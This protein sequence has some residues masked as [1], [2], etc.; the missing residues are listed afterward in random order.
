MGGSARD[1]RVARCRL[2]SRLAALARGRATAWR[3]PK[4]TNYAS[5][6]RS[7]TPAIPGLTVEVRDLGSRLKSGTR[8]RTT[9]SFSG[10]PGEPYLRVGPAGV[11]ENRRS[12]AVF[13]NRTQTIVAERAVVVRRRRAY[14]VAS[15]R[16]RPGRVL[17]RPPRPLDGRVRNRRRC[18][19]T[20]VA[21]HLVA[22]GSSRFSTTGRACGARRPS[23]GTRSV[24]S[25]TVKAQS[26]RSIEPRCLKP[27]RPFSRGGLSRRWDARRQADPDYALDRAAETLELFPAARVI[28]RPQGQTAV[29]VSLVYK[30]WF[31]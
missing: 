25:R 12:P 7:V 23:L 29:S 27:C 19:P 16:R 3:A 24:R 31:R 17:A 11:Y 14:R 1:R 5:R 9:S 22:T 2:R 10:T 15:H 4:P 20:P 8:P 6:V 26:R 30:L 13:L 28:P 18:T 21:V